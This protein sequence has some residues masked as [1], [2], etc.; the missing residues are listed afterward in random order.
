VW[1]KSIHH[2]L[3]RVKLLQHDNTKES[4]SVVRRV[5]YLADINKNYDLNV[6]LI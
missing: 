2:T 4:Y 3:S 6:L 1:G 5:I